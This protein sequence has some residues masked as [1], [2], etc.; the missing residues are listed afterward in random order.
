MKVMDEEMEEVAA[1]T[2]QYAPSYHYNPVYYPLSTY[3]TSVT[4]VTPV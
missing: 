2:I 1:K 3:P 4:Q